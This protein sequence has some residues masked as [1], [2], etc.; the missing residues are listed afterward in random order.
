MQIEII[1][2]TL[3]W[4]ELKNKTSSGRDL[5]QVEMVIQTDGNAKWFCHFGKQLEMFL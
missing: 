3:E 5:E 4:L 2:Y 1:P